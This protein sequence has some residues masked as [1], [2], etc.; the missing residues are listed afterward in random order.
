MPSS[1]E[2]DESVYCCF[3]GELLLRSKAAILT[4]APPAAREA[5]QTVFCHGTCFV[6]LLDRK[7]P[8]HSHLVDD[9]EPFAAAAP[10]GVGKP[11]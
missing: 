3:C 11:N 7:V 5:T 10:T 6:P 9:F 4:V 8:Y 2:R 1:A